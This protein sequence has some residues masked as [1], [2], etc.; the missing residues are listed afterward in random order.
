MLRVTS[1]DTALKGKDLEDT[2]EALLWFPI[3]EV[4]PR[5]QKY[6]VLARKVHAP[7]V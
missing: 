6:L 4:L 7:V 5:T 1:K 2:V 3:V